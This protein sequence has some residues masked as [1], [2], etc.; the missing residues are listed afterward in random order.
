MF[1][2]LLLTAQ[3]R[4]EVGTLEWPELDL[5]NATWTIPREKAKNDKA[6]EVQ[7]SAAAG[8]I[9]RAL[10]EPEDQRRRFVFQSGAGERPISGFSRAKRRLDRA[11]VKMRRE[12]L[13]LPVDD[14]KYRKA[15]NLKPDDKLPV[16]I[17]KWIL[18][19]LRRTA[20]TG[21]AKLNIPPHVV[22]KI[23]NHT[24]GTIRGVAAVYNRFGYLEER[25]QTL[26]AWGQYVEQLVGRKEAGNVTQL[27]AAS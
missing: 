5:D 15:L 13:G 10:G 23:L 1:K 6:H 3:R 22:D 11:M 14:D 26:A 4:D 19:D 18:Q 16:E 2:L 25:R 8:E 12:E 21:M 24:G 17:P 7:L 9:L 27:R 20:T